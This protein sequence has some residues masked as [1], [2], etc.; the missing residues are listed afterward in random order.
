MTLY[1]TNALSEVIVWNEDQ[2][3]EQL[4]LA[5]KTGWAWVASRRVISMGS[6]GGFVY[7]CYAMVFVEKSC[8]KR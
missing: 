5:R 7:G 2:K 1:P 3:V 8:L 4:A 6:T